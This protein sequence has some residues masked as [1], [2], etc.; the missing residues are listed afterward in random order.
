MRWTGWAYPKHK[1]PEFWRDGRKPVFCV[2][3]V[4]IFLLMT[5]QHAR[6]LIAQY[7]EDLP[8]ELL[9]EVVDFIEFVRLKHLS[10]PETLAAT[11]L[12]EMRQDEQLHLDQDFENL[13]R[14]YPKLND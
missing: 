13:N 10:L 6:T 7:T 5:T 2:N 1:W 4:D 12:R 9:R 3:W 8:E 14:D 11:E